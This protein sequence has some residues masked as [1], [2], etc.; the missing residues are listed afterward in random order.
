MIKAGNCRRVVSTWFHP[1]FNTDVPPEGL[2]RFI[3]FDT[4][5]FNVLCTFG[6][7]ISGGNKQYQKLIWKKVSVYICICK[8]RSMM[9]LSGTALVSVNMEKLFCRQIYGYMFIILQ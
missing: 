7:Q 1:Q 4:L 3:S 9:Q 2:R 5:H 6:S 8:Q